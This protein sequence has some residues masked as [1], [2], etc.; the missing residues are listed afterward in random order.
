MISSHRNERS[1][2]YRIKVVLETEAEKIAMD[3]AC[4]AVFI[5]NY[6][7]SNIFARSRLV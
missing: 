5:L 1:L 4:D 7:P 6:N 2:K 3:T